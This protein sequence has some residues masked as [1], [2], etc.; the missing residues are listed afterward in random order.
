MNRKKFCAALLAAAFGLGAAFCAPAG[1]AAT[2]EEIA[3][4]SVESDGFGFQYWNEDAQPFLALTRY[5][6][7]V[8][9]PESEHF[10]PLEDRV[11]VFDMD[12]T[13]LCET[14]PYY[15]DH[16][17]FLKRTLHDPN[18]A[19]S[20]DDK[21]FALSLERW[22]KNRDTSDNLGSSAPHQSSVFAGTSYADYEAYVKRF[23]KT[24]V[25]GLAPLKWG[26]AFYLPMVEA[27]KYL[28]ANDFKIYVVSG[29]ER[30]LARILVC[31][32]LDIPTEN[33]IGTDIKVMA[34]HQGETD[35]LQYTYQSDDYLVRGGFV[36]KNLKMNKVSAIVREI[37]RQPVLAFGNSSGDSAM[38][39]YTINGNKYRSAAFFLL[40]DDLERELGNLDKAAKCREL[41]EKNGWIPVSMR[42][43]FATIYGEDVSRTDKQ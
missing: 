23:M 17:L 9:D 32:V 2:R 10:I 41:A 27:M 43:D 4:I 30:E 1:E 14:A 25:N 38:L 3:Q 40:C 31:D 39:N 6:E 12:G 18:Y 11:A 5:V 19:P 33:I 36:I 13:F 28:Q 37:G 29:S 35:G 21:D 42:D 26:E 8:T 20:K 34:A 16:M 7:D 24:P 15:F 22:L